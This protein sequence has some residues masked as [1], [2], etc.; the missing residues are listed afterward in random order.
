MKIEFSNDQIMNMIEAI[1][2][3]V[4]QTEW[5]YNINRGG[6]ARFAIRMHRALNKLGIK[7]EMCVELGHFSKSVK[8][9]KHDIANY[10]QLNPRQRDEL[11]FAHA[12]IHIPH[13]KLNFDGKYASFGPKKGRFEDNDYSCT[14]TEQEMKTVIR[15]GFWNTSYH[16]AD[17]PEMSKIVYNTAKKIHKFNF[18]RS[19]NGT[20]ILE[21]SEPTSKSYFDRL[22]DIIDCTTSIA[23]IRSWSIHHKH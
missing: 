8:E 3:Q 15:L 10:K 1:Q 5:G 16:P 18:K 20:T 13:M 17:N 21:Q 7:N 19:N 14:Y 22:C 9:T 6:C 2:D 23:N 12:W 11:S 4:A